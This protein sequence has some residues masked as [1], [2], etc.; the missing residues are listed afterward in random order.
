MLYEITGSIKRVGE[1]ATFGNKGFTKRSFRIVTDDDKFPETLEF[2]CHNDR[3]A[4]LNGL[5]E[6]EHVRVAFGIRGNYWAEKD[7]I[8]TNL[9][10]IKVATSEQRDSMDQRPPVEPEDVSQA[11][12]DDDNLPF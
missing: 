1:S 2:E 12:E 5:Q 4:Q 8:F 10:A 7:R 3:C 11:P 9:V 6:N